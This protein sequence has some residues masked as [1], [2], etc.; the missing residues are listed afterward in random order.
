MGVDIDAM[1][2]GMAGAQMNGKGRK[3]GDGKYRVTAKSL[4]LKKGGY[5]G[6][7]FIFEYDV[8]RSD[9]EE[10]PVGSARSYTVN[11][12]SNQAFGDIKAVIFALIMGRDPSSLAD[13]KRFAAEHAEA[14]DWFKAAIDPEAAKKMDVAENF[15]AGLEVDVEVQWVKTKENRDFAVH[16][17]SPVPE[18]ATTDAAA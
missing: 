8:A 18:A 13:T 2:S 9:N 12:K 1:F 16:R 14:T 6:D 5:Y 17:W 10:H 11:L 7:S 15:V 3:L 4:K